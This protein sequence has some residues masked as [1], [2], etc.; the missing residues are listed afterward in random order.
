M[1][2]YHFTASCK[3]VDIISERLKEHYFPQGTSIEENP[4]KTVDVS[5]DNY[6]SN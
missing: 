5:T 2:Q 1:L 6:Y 4:K 3:D